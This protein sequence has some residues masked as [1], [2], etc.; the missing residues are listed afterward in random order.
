MLVNL[1]PQRFTWR[2]NSYRGKIHTNELW[3]T[4]SNLPF[5]VIGMFRLWS[6]QDQEDLMLLY[7]FYIAVGICGGIHHAV[8]VRG[9][10]ILNWIPILISLGLCS[11]YKV[12]KTVTMG[13][14]AQVG[15]SVVIFQADNFF[16]V[17]PVPWGCVM[18]HIASAL[19]I[20]S[21][22]MDFVHHECHW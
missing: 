7:F 10:I 11:Y 1:Q 15:F 13:T 2:P 21:A 6:Y 9:S 4:I 8:R 18:W 5:V 17:V 19:S 12:W 20:D 14:W 22:Y 16:Q 3:S